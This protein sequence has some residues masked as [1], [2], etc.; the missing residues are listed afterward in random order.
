MSLDYMA[1]AFGVSTT[2]IDKELASFITAGRIHAKIDKGKIHI[3]DL[4]TASSMDHSVQ[5]RPKFSILY[6]LTKYSV[7]GIIETNRPDE[8]N[9]QYQSVIKKG[10]LLLNRVQKLSRVI[11]I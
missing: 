3:K 9:R 7:N 1:Q 6:V 5:V 2:F 4:R 11:N 10:D 8:K